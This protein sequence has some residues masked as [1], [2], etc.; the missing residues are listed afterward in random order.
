MNS[1]LYELR[2]RS[3]KHKECL[4]N[5]AKTQSSIFILLYGLFEK[6]WM[7]CRYIGSTP[8]TPVTVTNE[9]KKGFPNLKRISIILVVD[10]E[11]ASRVWVGFSRFK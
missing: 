7:H 2:I 10:E 4:W 11:S 5:A 9:G 8:A 3:V 6:R 1:Y